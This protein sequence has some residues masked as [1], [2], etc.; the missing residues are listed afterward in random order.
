MLSTVCKIPRH[1]EDDHIEYPRNTG[2]ELGVKLQYKAFKKCQT[3]LTNQNY[4]HEISN[5]T[6]ECVIAFGKDFRFANQKT[7]SEIYR[8]IM[9]PVL[10]WCET[11]SIK[12][13]NNKSR[14]FENVLKK[15]SSL[16]V[17]VTVG[18][19]KLHYGIFKICTP[20]P[21]LLT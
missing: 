6:L 19:R 12:S 17:K 2:T 7:R 18:W 14:V 21:T 3:T 1:K 5:T 10:F 13:T 8:S 9:L 4:M 20:L 11:W 15:F 16:R